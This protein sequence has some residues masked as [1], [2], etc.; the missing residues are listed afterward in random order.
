MLLDVQL[1]GADSARNVHVL[2]IG[3]G[4]ELPGL[5]LGKTLIQGRLGLG[6]LNLDAIDVLMHV[7]GGG[8]AADAV[9][10]CGYDGDARRSGA[11]D[12]AGGVPGAGAGEPAAR[13][14]IAEREG[15]CGV[16]AAA[17]DDVLNVDANDRGALCILARGGEQLSGA[18]V[19]GH[20]AGR[21]QGN[22][23][24]AS[25]GGVAGAFT[26]AAGEGSEQGDG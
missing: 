17:G 1:Y 9:D 13:A 4:L 19:H 24:D 7:D 11:A 12:G 5:S 2:V 3:D 18:D 10:N 21:V 14:V 23:F 8:W 15:R 20:V 25:D 22:R 6:T 26:Q 16:R